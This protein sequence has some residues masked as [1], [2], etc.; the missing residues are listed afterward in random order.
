MILLIGNKGVGR[1]GKR[2]PAKG[3]SFFEIMV[4]VSILAVGIIVIYQAFF[5]SMNY[6]N[7]L[8]IRLYADWLLD[9]KIADLQYYFKKTGEL[10][11]VK[12]EK[13]TVIV[14][15]KTVD[16]QYAMSLKGSNEIENIYELNML[17]SWFE[18]DRAFKLSRAAYL[19]FY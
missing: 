18:Q 4:T 1:V 19:A 6:I 5:V 11:S 9:R 8:T 12:N 17:I 14:N 13:D 10:P 2:E 15:N 3:F 7:R 16:F